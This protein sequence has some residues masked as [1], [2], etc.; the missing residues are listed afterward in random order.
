MVWIVDRIGRSFDLDGRKII[1]FTNSFLWARMLYGWLRWPTVTS[2]HGEEFHEHGYMGHGSSLYLPSLHVPLVILFP[3]PVPKSKTISEPVSLRDIPSTIVDL[4]KLSVDANFPGNSLRRYWD[5]S[6]KQDV[7]HPQLLAEVPQ[8]P[9][10]AQRYPVSKG[11]MKSLVAEHF[12]YI[13]NGDGS[14]ELYNFQND[15]NETNEL[16]RSEEERQVLDRFRS[17]LK[18]TF[19]RN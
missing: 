6:L 7:E 3:S 10:V 11:N 17:F 13:K 16:S 15:P 8:A 5:A 18:T 4:L 2:D 9:N 1:V 14:E 12:H 19:Q